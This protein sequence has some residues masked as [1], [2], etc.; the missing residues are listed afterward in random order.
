M[1]NCAARVSQF[2]CLDCSRAK[3]HGHTQSDT[4][5]Q[6]HR[7]AHTETKSQST[8]ISVQYS[9]LYSL[10]CLLYSSTLMFNQLERD[11]PNFRD[12]CINCTVL[13]TVLYFGLPLGEVDSV[14]VGSAQY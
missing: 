14:N 11:D 5:S 1:P 12:S 2:E 7:T 3:S 10:H 13:T 8:Q 4:H 6:N 9:T